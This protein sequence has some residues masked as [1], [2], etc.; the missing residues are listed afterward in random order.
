[1][2]CHFKVCWKIC[3]DTFI[4]FVIGMSWIWF[5]WQTYHQFIIINQSRMTMVSQHQIGQLNKKCSYSHDELVIYLI[6]LSIIW[7]ISWFIDQILLQ[8]DASCLDFCQ[9]K[10][11]LDSQIQQILSEKKIF[12]IQKFLVGKKT[13]FCSES[14]GR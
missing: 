1:M 14:S 12:F 11:F 13:S 5:L 9:P 10:S 2:T 6:W 3:H 4:I 8:I 7:P